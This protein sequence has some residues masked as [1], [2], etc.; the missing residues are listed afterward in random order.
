MATTNVQ[1]FTTGEVAKHNTKDDCW[2]IIDGKVYDVTDFIEMHPAGAQIILDLGGQDVTDQFLAFH[3]MSVFDKYAPQLFK[4]L[5]RGA[6]ST[7]ESKEKRSTQL[8]RVPYAEPSYW[9]GFKSPYY[10]ESHTNFRLAVRRFIAKEI[11]DA[12]IDTYVKSGDA[13]EKDLFLKMGRAGILAANLGP[14]K[15]LLEYKGPLPSGIKAKDFDYFHEMIL[16]DEFYRIGAPGLSDGLACGLIIGLPPVIKFGSKEL[17]KRIVPQCLSGEKRICLAITEPQAG[18]DVA[19]VQCRAVKSPCGKYYT[20]TGT[21]K[22]ITNGCQSDYFSCA[23]R[24]GKKGLKGVSLLLIERGEGVTT[25]KIPTGYS[26]CAGTSLVI[27][28]NV[29]VPVA[30]LLGPENGGFKCI[31]HNFNHE[32]W[33][34]SVV[35]CS[36]ARRSLEEVT[37]QR[38]QTL[39]FFFSSIFLGTHTPNR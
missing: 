5:V 18:S 27:F 26:S 12:E 36:C 38:N 13:P 39:L 35:C 7:F 20:V 28:E 1:T 11:D 14:G 8:S 29:R 25:K 19:N 6:T 4:G 21:K 15:H 34:I 16:H 2:V 17:Q 10:N 31:M 23:V 24:T 33:Y 3:R 9:Q 37:T 32:R 30:N 22:W